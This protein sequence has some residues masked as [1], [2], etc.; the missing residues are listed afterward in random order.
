VGETES[1]KSGGAVTVR[2]A[3]AVWVRVPEV[4]VNVMVYGPDEAVD[5]GARWSVPE[6]TPAAMAT[7]HDASTQ[8]MP[9]GEIVA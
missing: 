4:A 3:V 5:D 7:V 1:A 9:E 8:L 2:V 6:V